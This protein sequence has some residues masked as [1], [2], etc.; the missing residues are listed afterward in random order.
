M[1]K[2]PTISDLPR[3]PGLT[4]SYNKLRGET[5]KFLHVARN[6]V[7]TTSTSG[8]KG[9]PYKRRLQELGVPNRTDWQQEALKLIARASRQHETYLNS[10]VRLQSV[11]GKGMSPDLVDR[12]EPVTVV[13]KIEAHSE[14][15]VR[16]RKHLSKLA[17]EILALLI[18]PHQGSGN[19]D[20]SGVRP[21]PAMVRQLLR[22]LV[23]CTF[24]ALAPRLSATEFEQLTDALLELH[25]RLGKVERPQEFATALNRIAGN[26]LRRD[27][28]IERMREELTA[29][30]R[31]YGPHERGRSPEELRQRLED[32]SRLAAGDLLALL[33]SACIGGELFRT[34][35]AKD[36]SPLGGLGD[37]L[38]LLDRLRALSIDMDGGDGWCGECL[39]SFPMLKLDEE[40]KQE[41]RKLTSH[42]GQVEKLTKDLLDI[43]GTGKDDR[44]GIES[45]RFSAL[46]VEMQQAFNRLLHR[47]GPDD[48]CLFGTGTTNVSV[49]PEVSRIRD[50]GNSIREYDLTLARYLHSMRE[51]L[52]SERRWRVEERDMV[53]DPA[54]LMKQ[55]LQ[56]NRHFIQDK[57]VREI[58]AR[59]EET[60]KADLSARIS[61]FINRVRES[62]MKGLPPG[63]DHPVDWASLGAHHAQQ[64]LELSGAF[65]QWSKTVSEISRIDQEITACNLAID[66]VLGPEVLESVHRLTGQFCRASSF[67]EKTW[68]LLHRIGSLNISSLKEWEGHFNRIEQLAGKFDSTF[69]SNAVRKL[70]SGMM[71]DKAVD[72]TMEFMGKVLPTVHTLDDAL[73]NNKSSG[74][75]SLFKKFR[76]PTSRTLTQQ[77]YL[78]KSVG[79]V[80]DPE[81]LSQ[82]IAPLINNIPGKGEL[83][84]ISRL[85]HILQDHQEG[86]EMLLDKI[87]MSEEGVKLSAYLEQNGLHF[88]P[89]R[90][91]EIVQG[92]TVQP[93][94][95]TFESLTKEQKKIYHYIESFIEKNVWRIDYVWQGILLQLVD[96]CCPPEFELEK[97]MKEIAS[98]E[99]HLQRPEKSYRKWRQGARKEQ[100]RK[101]IEKLN[102]LRSDVRDQLRMHGCTGE[103]MEAREFDESFDSILALWTDDRQVRIK[104]A[105]YAWNLAEAMEA[106][107]KSLSA[108]EK[109][110]SRAH[111][112]A[113]YMASGSSRPTAISKW[114]QMERALHG[115]KQDDYLF[116]NHGNSTQLGLSISVPFTNLDAMVE[117]VS[118]NQEVMIDRQ[119]DCLRVRLYDGTGWQWKGDLSSGMPV[120]GI[121]GAGLGGEGNRLHQQG[122]EIYFDPKTFSGGYPEMC[123]ELARF[124]FDADEHK[125]D[126]EFVLRHSSRIGRYSQKTSNSREDVNGNL[127]LDFAASVVGGLRADLGLKTRFS[128]NRQEIRRNVVSGDLYSDK[129][130]RMGR[131]GSTRLGGNIAT[132]IIYPLMELGMGRHIHDEWNAFNYTI[133]SRIED[134]NSLKKVKSAGIVQVGLH[135]NCKKMSRAKK[136]AVFRKELGRLMESMPRL[137]LALQRGQYEQLLD[138]LV[139]SVGKHDEDGKTLL[140]IELE[141]GLK[142]RLQLDQLSTELEV[143][144]AGRIRSTDEKRQAKILSKEID[145][146]VADPGNYQLKSV[147]LR[148]LH[149]GYG[150]DSR[151]GYMGVGA[152]YAL[153]FGVEYYFMKRDW[154]EMTNA[155]VQIDLKEEQRELGEPSGQQGEQRLGE[156]PDP[157]QE[158]VDR[159]S[160]REFVVDR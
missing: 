141:L 154:H 26:Y 12:Q 42:K 90:A 137:R 133:L 1:P 87:P 129:R 20:G 61:E 4:S 92:D 158:L 32:S 7:S 58:L 70:A 13:T 159:L 6:H 37:W 157:Q 152:K 114:V 36:I 147:A 138:R 135:R 29:M 105:D 106:K 60:W 19:K 144:R 53:S 49:I 151:G 25:G 40:R 85:I 103:T 127:G 89:G 50:L 124:F 134:P 81:K 118:S 23:F 156:I 148:S 109:Q 101:N 5:V 3:R 102:K 46:K 67:S 8:R 116:L 35:V 38:P 11:V 44:N 146:I 55:F 64:F 126:M 139:K 125:M 52:R 97:T 68:S 72:S 10:S 15:R 28:G 48:N 150:S 100:Y 113:G 27:S 98:Y 155:I 9:S 33:K 56:Q 142:A 94:N 160:N 80:D 43:A 128:R 79:K 132:M 66:A 21:D 122:T 111:E 82:K 112:I 108:P 75:K 104:Q 51:I 131:T 95:T 76:S 41:I 17:V 59:P 121:I 16:Q 22:Q 74:K 117:R 120:V 149:E 14:E 91:I 24:P 115:L 18:E 45:S 30:A 140:S 143:L 93:T 2:K 96:H 54:R 63:P 34:L 73:V 88:D 77:E 83:P 39:Q 107:G 86:G 153:R 57:G 110:G 99:E 119:G 78:D 136:K 69:K 84:H 47:P 65:E 31:R 123:R 145:R 130:Y 71:S 62:L